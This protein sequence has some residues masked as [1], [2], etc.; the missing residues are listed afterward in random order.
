MGFFPLRALNADV[1]DKVIASL[2]SKIENEKIWGLKEQ[3]M[4]QLEALKRDDLPDCE[5]ISALG[6]APCR[7]EFPVRPRVLARL[8]LI[9]PIGYMSDPREPG[10]KYITIYGVLNHPISRGT[11]VSFSSASTLPEQ[12][13]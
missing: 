2:T 11:I 13:F 6:Y 8:P 3:W 9:S 12:I 4:L 5:F 7:R 1:A 10:K